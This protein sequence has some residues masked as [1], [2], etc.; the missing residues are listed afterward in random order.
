[1]K[2]SRVTKILFILCIIIN[3]N[4][5]RSTTSTAVWE[6]GEF[7]NATGII[8]QRHRVKR[9]LAFQPGTRIMVRANF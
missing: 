8:K 4:R 9:N 7:S 1:M 2:I 3:S 6:D 5:V